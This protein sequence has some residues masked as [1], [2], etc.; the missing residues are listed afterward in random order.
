MRISVK[1]MAE[2]PTILQKKCQTSTVI[3]IPLEKIDF[4]KTIELDGTK[5]FP[6]KIERYN[7]RPSRNEP[8]NRTS[9]AKG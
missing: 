1:S 6:R 8:T 9:K 3:H 5:P 7:R 2:I 4:Q